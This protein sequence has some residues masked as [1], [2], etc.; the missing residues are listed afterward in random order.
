MN[1]VNIYK[2]NKPSKILISLIWMK[3]LTIITPIT[4]KKFDLY[5][6]KYDYK[7]VFHGKFY[8]HNKSELEINQ[9]KLH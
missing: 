4:K 8:P 1:L 9:L 6:V 5:L 2:Q 7:I 3:N